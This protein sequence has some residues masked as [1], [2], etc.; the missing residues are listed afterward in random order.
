[1]CVECGCTDKKTASGLE[2]KTGRPDLPS[3]GYSGVGG[4]PIKKQ[5]K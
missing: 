1:M 4:S 3:G 5:G 2:S